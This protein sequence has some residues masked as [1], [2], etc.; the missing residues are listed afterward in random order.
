MRDADALT[1]SHRVSVGA[2]AGRHHG[3]VADGDT[4]TPTDSQPA[5]EALVIDL[6]IRGG[7][8]ITAS[9]TFVADVGIRDGK[10]VQIA[11]DLRGAGPE[12]DATGKLVVPGAV[13]AHV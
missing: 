6:V 4:R 7:T 5:E 11:S 10:V 9:D 12:L 2:A 3:K 13:D 8:I 1:I